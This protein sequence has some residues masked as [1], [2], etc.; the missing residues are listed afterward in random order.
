MAE[1]EVLWKCSVEASNDL[2]AERIAR[3]VICNT[4]PRA[5]ANVV[6]IGMP[7]PIPPSSPEIDHPAPGR[8]ARPT[9][10]LVNGTSREILLRLYGTAYWST[11]KAVQD[12][13]LCRPALTDYYVQ[14]PSSHFE[15]EHQ[16]EARMR[17][18]E[19]A[20]RELGQ[21]WMSLYAPSENIR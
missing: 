10:D 2:E 3:K 5:L 4:K 20:R 13:A 6:P 17:L 7:P 9:P 8:L 12:T 11:N 21:I 1:Y 14:G 16:H 18:L 19:T 15:A